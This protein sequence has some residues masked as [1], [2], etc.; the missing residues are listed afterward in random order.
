MTSR[1]IYPRWYF[2]YNIG[3]T[4]MVSS[5]FKATHEILQPNKIHLITDTDTANLF[6]NDPYLNKITGLS[7]LHSKLF[8][9]KIFKL[10]VRIPNT[11]ILWP[12]WRHDTFNYLGAKKNL[13]KTIESPFSNFISIN[14]AH[15]IDT[16]LL[17]HNDLRPRIYLTKNE[18]KIA[19]K[20]IPRKAIAIHV[21]KI[22]N[23]HKRKDGSQFRYNIEKWKIL[24]KTIKQQLPNLTIIEIG[25][26]EFL[27]IG[28]QH[29]GFKPI[30]EIAAIINQMELVI[31]SD[32]GMHHIC[33]SID[34][35][36]L[37]FQAY[38]WAPV[39]IVKMGN[40]VFTSNCHTACSSECEVLHEIKGI[41]D[42]RLTCNR[43][44]YQLDPKG[45]AQEAIKY[46]HS[47]N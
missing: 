15:Q 25:N 14:Y 19:Q 16:K 17:A 35:K 32:G 26:K 38:E 12:S 7:K 20:L 39:E 47:L 18:N 23:S 22:R 1:I 4:V 37:I 24:C 8:S 36:V 44:C 43:E 28:D 33:N 31:L 27:G 46:L 34:K 11:Y 21:A 45:L 13:Q 30:R 40:A 3:D 10:L 5:I 6:H 41:A 29:I 9:K 42:A 2:P